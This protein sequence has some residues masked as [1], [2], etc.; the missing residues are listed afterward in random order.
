[1]CIQLGQTLSLQSQHESSHLAK[2]VR[3]LVHPETN[4]VHIML[5]IHVGNGL[6]AVSNDKQY[7]QYRKA[8]G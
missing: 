3:R 1:M 8:K 5:N 4:S 6:A 2:F 7:L